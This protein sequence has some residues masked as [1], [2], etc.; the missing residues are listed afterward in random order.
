[1]SLAERLTRLR[2]RLS[3][4]PREMAE[5]MGVTERVYRKYEKQE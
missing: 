2:T 3:L 5:K 4:H 1:M